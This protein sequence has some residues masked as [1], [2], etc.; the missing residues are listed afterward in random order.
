MSP[1][2]PLT[3]KQV[4]ELE[5][6][7]ARNAKIGQPPDIPDYGF[8]ERGRRIVGY[9]PGNV[10]I[11]EKQR[12]PFDAWALEQPPLDPEV[13]AA[14]TTAKILLPQV[15]E[16]LR[17]VISEAVREALDEREQASEEVE[18]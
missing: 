8:D 5:R 10:P 13:R 17:P 11:V 3:T 16:A 1:H 4:A 18:Q 15:I 2:R 7:A 14:Q 9:D 12:D 6:K